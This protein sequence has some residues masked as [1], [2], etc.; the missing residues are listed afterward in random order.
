MKSP[1]IASRLRLAAALSVLK[2]AKV[3]KYE[4]QIGSNFRLLALVVQVR[5]LFS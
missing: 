3:E 1:A 5:S 4:A 2:L